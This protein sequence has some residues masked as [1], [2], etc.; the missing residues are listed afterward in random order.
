MEEMGPL[1]GSLIDLKLSEPTSSKNK[2][3]TFNSKGAQIGYSCLLEKTPRVH[4]EK[5]LS[6][7]FMPLCVTLKAYLI[8]KFKLCETKIGSPI[9]WEEPI[10]G[11]TF[12]M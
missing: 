8:A 2:M 12:R 11:V 10:R 7:N 4:E 1:P 6:I 5:T 9:T 3:S